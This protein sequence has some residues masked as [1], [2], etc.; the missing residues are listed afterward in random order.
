ML[1]LYLCRN[2]LLETSSSNLIHHFESLQARREEST[3]ETLKKPEDPFEKVI[4]D[5]GDQIEKKTF[6]DPFIQHIQRL[7]YFKFKLIILLL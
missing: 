1:E 2:L 7:E 3:E 5:V 6:Q 4:G